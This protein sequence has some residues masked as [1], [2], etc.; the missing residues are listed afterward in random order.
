MGHIAK[1]FFGIQYA[2]MAGTAAFLADTTENQYA[3]N[4]IFIFIIYDRVVNR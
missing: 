2:K 3:C 4:E 1:L